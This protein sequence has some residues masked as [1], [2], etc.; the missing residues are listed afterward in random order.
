MKAIQIKDEIN[1]ISKKDIEARRLEKKED[2]LLRKLKD[3]HALQQETLSQIKDI[4]ASRYLNESSLQKLDRKPIL[5]NQN[6]G[7]LSEHI[8]DRIIIE[9]KTGEVKQ[10]I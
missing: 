7:Q 1:K 10:S 9:D 4:F 2:Q 8:A 5:V 3:T 6:S